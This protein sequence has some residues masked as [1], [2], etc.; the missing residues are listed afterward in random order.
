HDDNE[1]DLRYIVLYRGENEKQWKV[2][3]DKLT[4]KFYTWDATSLPDGAYYLRIVASDAPSNPTADA[5][6]SSRESERFM[7]DNTPPTIELLES[8]V[9]AAQRKDDSNGSASG[10]QRTA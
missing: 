8:S 7:I 6:T 5:L 4:E 3:K 9:V 10:S 1:D 2:L